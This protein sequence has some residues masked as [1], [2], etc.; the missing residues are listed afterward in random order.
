MVK[1][2]KAVV[3]YTE[4]IFDSVEEAVKFADMASETINEAGAKICVK[5]TYETETEE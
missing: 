3:N 1:K 5:I 2:V 4:F